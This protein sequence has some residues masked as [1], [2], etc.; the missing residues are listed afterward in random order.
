[1]QLIEQKKH[2]SKYKVS[3]FSIKQKKFAKTEKPKVKESLVDG[4]KKEM[5]SKDK[6]FE[7]NKKKLH[8][9]KI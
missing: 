8:G 2:S 1:M 5:E 9:V 7:E 6:K 4:H 3:K